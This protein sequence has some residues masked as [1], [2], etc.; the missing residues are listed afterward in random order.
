MQSNTE[1]FLPRDA[2]QSTVLPRQFVRP[3][4]HDVEV[5]WLHRLEFFKNNFTADLPRLSSHSPTSRIMHTM[6][7]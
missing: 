5:L 3:S 2:M 6:P 1:V 7:Y 4:V